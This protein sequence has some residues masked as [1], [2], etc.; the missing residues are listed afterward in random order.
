V[1]FFD[2]NETLLDLAAMRT[3]IGAALSGRPELLPLWFATTLQHTLVETAAGQYHDMAEIAAH[4]WDVAGAMW[5]GRRTSLS[6]GT[7]AGDHGARPCRG[8]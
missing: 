4:G 7:A 1:L 6:A 3:S 2:V 5:A 8:R